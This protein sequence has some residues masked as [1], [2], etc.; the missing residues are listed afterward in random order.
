MSEGYKRTG[1]HKLLVRFD[2]D[3]PFRFLSQNI[4]LKRFFL[5][6]IIRVILNEMSSTHRQTILITGVVSLMIP[7][8]NPSIYCFIKLSDLSM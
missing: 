4:A 1:Y 6:V 5:G 3:C 7:V 8:S 2:H